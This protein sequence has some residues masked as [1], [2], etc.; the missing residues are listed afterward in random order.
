LASAAVITLVNGFFH[1]A[2]HAHRMG[3]YHNAG[4]IRWI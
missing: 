3:L 1:L 2:L 4:Q